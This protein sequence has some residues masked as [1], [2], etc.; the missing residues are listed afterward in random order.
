MKTIKVILYI[1][2]LFCL[3]L[4]ANNSLQGDA[5][6]EKAHQRAYVKYGLL[7]KTLN[8]ESVTVACMTLEELFERYSKNEIG[9]SDV[10]IYL[11]EIEVD[12]AF[13]TDLKK[14][15]KAELP[16][17]DFVEWQGYSKYSNL[18]ENAIKIRGE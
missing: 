6:F 10:A 12:I 11:G 1:P 4:F 5:L 8:L 18:V 7:Y 16:K 15:L 2:A 9:F 3:G 17:N 13:L 14:Y